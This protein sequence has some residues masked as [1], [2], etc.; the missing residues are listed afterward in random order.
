MKKLLLLASVGVLIV[1]VVSL[2][3][4]GSYTGVVRPD[5]NDVTPEETSLPLLKYRFESLGEQTFP[6]SDIVLE[7]KLSGEDVF[8]SY[9]FSFTTQ[10][11][12]VTGL[13]NIPIEAGSYP[14]I[15]MLRGFVD[16]AVYETGIG[17]KRTAEAFAARGFITL[18]PDFF[19]YGRSD[20]AAQSALW[21]RGSGSMMGCGAGGWA[22]EAPG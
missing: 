13:A 1:S 10:G 11:K 3:E 18:A 9:L 6:G 17:T 16:P 19:G 22:G 21:G 12:T 7:E 2:A 14:V 20:G 5:V 15:V 8:S 4:Q